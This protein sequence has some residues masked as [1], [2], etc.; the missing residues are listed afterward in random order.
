MLMMHHISIWSSDN[1]CH[2]NVK[3]IIF[4]N[5]LF[6][7]NTD[8]AT[9]KED[10]VEEKNCTQPMAQSI[11]SVQR[12]HVSRSLPFSILP[13][14]LAFKYAF[15]QNVIIYT[16][17]VSNS[18]NRVGIDFPFATMLPETV[19]IPFSMQIRRNLAYF[20]LKTIFN[21]SNSYTAYLTSGGVPMG[22]I[23]FILSN[24]EPNLC[25][26]EC[27]CVVIPDVWRSLW[28]RK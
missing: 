14:H 17:A 23:Q 28:K 2:G 11:F 27:C 16:R 7:Q 10:E 4:K 19:P 21:K 12:A 26:S 24:S 3:C 1:K 13:S 25:K 20:R 22:H 6:H 9:K 18:L 5:P 15:I 8:A